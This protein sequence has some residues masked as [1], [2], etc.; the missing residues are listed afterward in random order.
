MGLLRSM[1]VPTKL[2]VS[3]LSEGCNRLGAIGRHCAGYGQEPVGYTEPIQ[4]L[5]FPDERHPGADWLAP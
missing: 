2:M 1:Q 5:P 4:N 3:D